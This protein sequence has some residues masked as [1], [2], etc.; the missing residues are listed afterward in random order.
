MLLQMFT[1]GCMPG[2]ANVVRDTIAILRFFGV[3]RG[4]MVP[5]APFG[6]EQL[7]M[8]VSTHSSKAHFPHH[9]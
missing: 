2:L 1:M 8:T 5:L 9:Q 3:V 4:T 7:T 6:P